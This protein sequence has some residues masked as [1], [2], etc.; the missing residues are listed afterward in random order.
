M[1]VST[2]IAVVLDRSAPV[3]VQVFDLTGKMVAS[4]FEGVMQPGRNTVTF[5][6]GNL[7][8]GIYFGKVITGEQQRVFKMIAR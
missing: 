8:G 4:L 1:L 7:P 6:A 5:N 2:F 3:R